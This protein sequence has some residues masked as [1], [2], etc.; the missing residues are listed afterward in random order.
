M[1][2]CEDQNRDEGSGMETTILYKEG[3]K[4]ECL[5]EEN[6]GRTVLAYS[7]EKM[8]GLEKRGLIKKA[9]VCIRHGMGSGSR[10][11]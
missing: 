11:L 9:H 3:G 1:N 2:G 5:R 8:Q 6:T 10:S 4:E 7:L